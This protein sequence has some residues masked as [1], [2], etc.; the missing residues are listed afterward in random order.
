MPNGD[1]FSR[2]C[3]QTWGSERENN[4]TA[5]RKRQVVPPPPGGWRQRA[6]AVAGAVIGLVSVIALGLV[7]RR[8]NMVSSIVVV[9]IYMAVVI[10]FALF[11]WQATRRV[12]CPQCKSEQAR[13]VYDQNRNEYLACTDC[14]YK[15][16]TGYSQAND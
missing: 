4:V 11:L 7:T 1:P 6:F 8:L 9:A 2:L 10:P 13:L 5:L 12:R 15:K 3:C 16:A 14:G